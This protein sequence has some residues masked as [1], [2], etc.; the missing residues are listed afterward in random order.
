MGNVRSPFGHP[1]HVYRSRNGAAA[2]GIALRPASQP[3]CFFKNSS[4]RVQASPAL[5]AS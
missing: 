3:M 2:T 5:G 4:V 1:T